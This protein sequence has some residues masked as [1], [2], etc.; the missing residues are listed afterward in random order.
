[1]CHRS[2]KFTMYVSAFCNAFP[3]IS[4]AVAW[5]KYVT[6]NQSRKY[7]VTNHSGYDIMTTLIG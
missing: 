1:M 2:L 7:H 3:F 4:I 5:L 6:G